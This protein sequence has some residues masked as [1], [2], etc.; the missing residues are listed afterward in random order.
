MDAVEIVIGEDGRILEPRGVTL[1]V[2]SSVALRPPDADQRRTRLQALWKEI[3]VHL[4]AIP[5]KPWP[6]ND[7]I[8]EKFRRK[9]LLD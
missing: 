9:G 8:V 4:D 7:P 5:K 6:D 1:R 2:P 3:D